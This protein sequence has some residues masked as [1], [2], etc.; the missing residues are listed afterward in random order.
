MKL[1]PCPFCGADGTRLIP[2]TAEGTTQVWCQSCGTRG[3]RGQVVSAID[4]WNE[5]TH[6][7]DI[8]GSVPMLEGAASRRMG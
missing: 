5:R 6:G 1:L 3:P 8:G 7:T 4:R 2:I